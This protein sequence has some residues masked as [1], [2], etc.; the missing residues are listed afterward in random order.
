MNTTTT[1]EACTIR[2]D[3]QYLTIWNS[4]ESAMLA[5]YSRPHVIAYPKQWVLT[6]RDGEIIR[7]WR[8][9]APTPQGILRT[10]VHHYSGLA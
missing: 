5:T 3:Q 2:D 7:V 6:G 1:V 10:I 9:C 8:F 4:D